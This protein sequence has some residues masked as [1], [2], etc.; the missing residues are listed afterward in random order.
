M[1]L[2]HHVEALQVET[3]TALEAPHLGSLPVV[4]PCFIN[5]HDS[6]KVAYTILV[7]PISPLFVVRENVKT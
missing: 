1:A 6:T 4:T 5:S 7:I 2:V 3:L